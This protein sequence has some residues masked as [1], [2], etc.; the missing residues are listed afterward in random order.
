MND[1]TLPPRRAMNAK[2][3][4][5]V[6]QLIAE[7]ERLRGG[8]Y[9]R[10]GTW[11]LPMICQHLASI[12]EYSIATPAADD[13]APSPEQAEAKSGF[14]SMVLNGMPPGIPV[15]PPFT[16]SIDAGPDQVDR[17]IAAMRA[18][19]AT[20]HQAFEFSPKFGPVATYEL[21]GLHL[22]HA[23]HHLS[24]LVPTEAARG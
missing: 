9:A 14:F 3:F 15:P 13:A 12:V 17:L 18:I 21:V 22:A 11:T 5:D 4:A 8:A 24:F 10:A 16:P 6:G 19:D 1:A 7:I 23:A 20:P 2:T